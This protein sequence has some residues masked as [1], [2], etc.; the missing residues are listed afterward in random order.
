MQRLKKILAVALCCVV[1][2]FDA[3][4]SYVYA[5]DVTPAYSKGKLA[6]DGVAWALLSA[7]GIAT[8]EAT[9]AV[10]YLTENVWTPLVAHLKEKWG[11]MCDVFIDKTNN[12]SYVSKDMMQDA[13][14]WGIDNK[15]WNVGSD[16]TGKPDLG[17][18]IHHFFDIYKF[19]DFLNVMIK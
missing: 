6:W 15:I 17:S 16:I 10:D 2:C 13:L 5:A 3:G 7:L 9:G 19:I 12:K 18:D 8:G 4:S 11:S 1:L 14:D